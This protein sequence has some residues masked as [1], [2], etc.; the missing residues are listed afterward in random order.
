MTQFNDE[1]TPASLSPTGRGL[2]AGQRTA[3]EQAPKQTKATPLVETFT[4]PTISATGRPTFFPLDDEGVFGLTGK[5]LRKIASDSF[6]SEDI[7]F[8]KRL[9]YDIPTQMAHA[10]NEDA[11]KKIVLFN[12]ENDKVF[13]RE[14]EQFVDVNDLEGSDFVATL[15]PDLA[16]FL[17]SKGYD[18]GFLEGKS[19]DTAEKNVRHFIVDDTLQAEIKANS[20]STFRNASSFTLTLLSGFVDPTLPIGIGAGTVLRGVGVSASKR[21]LKKESTNLLTQATSRASEI[22]AKN[23]SISGSLINN[24]WTAQHVATMIGVDTALVSGT[25]DVIAQHSEF[26]T[27]EYYFGD[28]SEPWFSPTRTLASGALGG[29][30]GGGLAKILGVS[31]LHARR[32]A[33]IEFFGN[34]IDPTGE[35]TPHMKRIRAVLEMDQNGILDVEVRSGFAPHEEA[36]LVDGIIQHAKLYA[37]LDKPSN[38]KNHPADLVLELVNKVMGQDTGKEIIPK[39]TRYRR[40]Q[41]EQTTI[42]IQLRQLDEAKAS[43]ENELADFVSLERASELEADLDLDASIDSIA[44]DISDLESLEAELKVFLDQENSLI[45]MKDESI[46]E[47]KALEKDFTQDGLT[48]KEVLRAGD[49]IQQIGN[50]AKRQRIKLAQIATFF[51]KNPTYD[52]AVRFLDGMDLEKTGGLTGRIKAMRAL[53]DIKKEADDLEVKIREDTKPDSTVAPD[54]VALNLERLKLMRSQE[55]LI[56]QR[57]A[58]FNG[59]TDQIQDTLFSRAVQ[60]KREAGKR[61]EE[62]HTATS[63]SA[64][65]AKLTEATGLLKSSDAL[66]DKV[67]L[68]IAPIADTTAP[69]V[70]GPG[71]FVGFID[72][73]KNTKASSLSTADQVKW[74][75]AHYLQNGNNISLYNK[76]AASRI[77]NNRVFNAMSGVFTSRNAME[78]AVE[79]SPLLLSAFN[80]IDNVTSVSNVRD[81]GLGHVENLQSMVSRR[82][83]LAL[84][85]ILN[86]WGRMQKELKGDLGALARSEGRAMQLATGVEVRDATELEIKLSDG[87]REWFDMFESDGVDSGYLDAFKEDYLSVRFISDI[88]PEQRGLIKNAIRGWFDA[89]HHYD[90]GHALDS[91][92]AGARL[93]QTKEGKD[94]TEFA[95]PRQLEFKEGEEITVTVKQ[96]KGRKKKGKEQ[97]FEDVERVL[98]MEE[99]FASKGVNRE[100]IDVWDILRFRQEDGTYRNAVE[101]YIE[102][103]HGDAMDLEL[104]NLTTNKLQNTGV[105]EGSQGSL[106]GAQLRSNANAERRQVFPHQIFLTDEILASGSVITNPHL[107]YS[108]YI[109]SAGFSILEQ[110]QVNKLMD[111]NRRIDMD[112]LIETALD[113]LNRNN[114]GALKKAELDSLREMFIDN[115]DAIAGRAYRNQEVDMPLKAFAAALKQIASVPV[116]ANIPLVMLGT[117]GIVPSLAKILTSGDIPHAAVDMLRGFQRSFDKD[118]REALGFIL[119]QMIAS[120]RRLLESGSFSEEVYFSYSSRVAAPFKRI[121][122]AARGE[123]TARTLAADTNTRSGRFANAAVAVTEALADTTRNFSSEIIQTN[124]LQGMYGSYALSTFQ[125]RVPKLIKA[126]KELR[127]AGSDPS[128]KVLR[129]IAR[130][131]GLPFGEFQIYVNEGLLD[132]IV[133]RDM[134]RLREDK[135]I[136]D[137]GDVSSV[138]QAI[139]RNEA[140]EVSTERDSFERVLDMV[141]NEVHKDVTMPTVFDRPVHG[142]HPAVS[143]LSTFLSFS[144]GFRSGKLRDLANASNFTATSAFVG[145]IFAEIM[146]QNIK[147]I[148]KKGH[149]IQEIVEGYQEDPMSTVSWAV[150]NVPLAGPYQQMVAQFMRSAASGEPLRADISPVF[151][152]V[153]NGFNDTN[154]F[155]HNPKDEEA[156]KRAAKFFPGLNSPVGQVL[157][158]NFQNTE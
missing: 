121:G 115:R 62:S 40:L 61:F 101:I 123:S 122:A 152:I 157:L 11:M 3:T 143:L 150:G 109:Q 37:S 149:S 35:S 112:G 86:P 57:D 90:D 74:L 118:Q 6:K 142:K 137:F 83:N 36:L 94:G 31:N 139:S 1:S 110:L 155:L 24:K 42:D 108:N 54:A 73:L 98:T 69:K 15:A 72:D 19:F 41:S 22:V 8:L 64:R 39:I 99:Y 82:Q 71:E 92:L 56:M 156:Q 23:G 51:K 117:E 5:K 113:E 33:E 4:P 89:Q 77:L 27:L 45:K 34:R 70:G 91:I 44:R 46:R 53:V 148:V 28:S 13:N 43:L 84:R 106:K 146:N 138:Y 25:F 141:R 105:S 2:A 135:E 20:D 49:R 63:N 14:T 29:L 116:N 96:K 119:D 133:L 107:I 93:L 103:Y 154:R 151:G 158:N 95:F 21:I 97:E 9:V 144:R 58:V 132:E 125:R 32:E 130:H 52:E 68:G 88:S 131:N 67:K 80:L 47:Q 10:V 17:E 127:E 153:K 124:L 111:G 12:P 128:E 18:F 38:G 120:Q 126:A 55:V 78:R 87:L 79:K 145:F 140:R 129:G 48:T 136:V 66:F 59:A 50:G 85:T 104:E 100:D 76:T 102:G 26:D 114:G 16:F 134:F 30:L 7:G 147:Q 75:R 65:T 60:L 81:F